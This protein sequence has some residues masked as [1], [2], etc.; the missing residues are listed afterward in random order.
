MRAFLWEVAQTI[1]NENK[2]R[3]Q[4]N[5]IA[6]VVPGKRAG[7]FLKKHLAQLYGK[8]ILP[9]SIY[10]LPDWFKMLSG[11]KNIGTFES[12]LLL[13]E[14]YAKEID[15]KEDFQMFMKWAPQ[16]MND[17]NDI[18][19]S[20]VSAAQ[21]FQNIKDIKGIEQWSLQGET[22]SEIQEKFLVFWEQFGKLY[23][24]FQKHGDLTQQWNYAQLT[25]RLAEKKIDIQVPH[26]KTYAVGLSSLTPAEEKIMDR[27]ALS[28][29]L[30]F[31]WDVDNYYF[32]NDQHEAGNFFRDLSQRKSINT[33][34]CLSAGKRQI[35]SFHAQTAYGNTIQIAES[36]QKINAEERSNTAIIMTDG[37]LLQ[38]L[39]SQLNVPEA[40]NVAMGWPIR[41]TAVYQLCNAY[42]EFIISTQKQKRIYFRDFNQFIDQP[43]IRFITESWRGPLQESLI[44]KRLTYFQFSKLKELSSEPQLQS[45]G[46]FMEYLNVESM[47]APSALAQ[48]TR[49]LESIA[50]HDSSDE[51][52][53]ESAFQLKEKLQSIAH[54]LTTMPQLNQMGSLEILF[55]HLIGKEQITFEGEPLQG[56]QIMG[57]IETRALDFKRVIFVQATEDVMPG[58]QP[59]QSLIPFDLRTAFGMPLPKDRDAS[60]A[61]NLYRLLQRAEEIQFYIPATT[62]DFRSVER[63]RYLQQLLWEWPKLN[64]QIEWKAF[65]ISAPKA[66]EFNISE[67]VLANELSMSQLTS[68]FASGISPSAINKFLQC[69]LDFYYRYIIGLGEINEMEEQLDSATIGSLVHKVLENWH[70]PKIGT[71]LTAQDI[72]IWRAECEVKLAETLRE[73]DDEMPIEGYNLLALEAAKKM[74]EKVLDYD[75]QLIQEN[76]PA[77]IL[78]TEQNVH[79]TV[80]L[81]D[82]TPL[83]FKGNIDRVHQSGGIIYILDYKTGQVKEKDLTLDPIDEESL[84]TEK[85]G[86]LIQIL[87]YAWL[88]HVHLHIPLEKMSIGLFP[89]AAVKGTPEFLQNPKSFLSSGFMDQSNEWLIHQCEMMLAQDRYVHKQDAHSCQFC[90]EAEG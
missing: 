45:I 62:S 32:Q 59:Y 27:V 63:S 41:N 47:D 60:Y 22:L 2:D 28:H 54:W 75:L 71:P 48:M 1:Y 56:L 79:T 25:R 6:V 35:T 82:G 14:V 3:Y 81:Q 40:I 65:Q 23:H 29:P 76:Q 58:N 83:V 11:K 57:M 90:R 34:S 55:Q 72:Q 20:L 84:F 38:P 18:D 7:L 31:I 70:R 15:Q 44:K 66:E 51:I 30:E 43:A 86:K 5:D 42:W 33:H 74:I 13:F 39:L 77:T 21:I 36:I 8:P 9:P 61:Y 19:Q 89:L 73:G 68:K 85:K 24:A 80:H 78:Y 46:Q 4:L 88:S 67:F 10:I 17:F 50:L 64:A 16:A 26:S 52:T 12:T 37:N 53:V 49:L 69:P 87:M